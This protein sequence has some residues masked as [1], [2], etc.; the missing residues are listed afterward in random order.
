MHRPAVLC[1]AAAA[2]CAALLSVQACDD[3]GTK[4]E[5]LISS[6]SYSGHENDLDANA[7]VRAYPAAVGTRLDD[8]QMCHRAGVAATDTKNV[9]NA[10]SY[11][12]IYAFNDT[13]YV[14]GVP[15]SYHD[16]LNAFGL[17]YQSHGKGTA[18]LAAIESLDSDGDTYA[19]KDEIADNRFPG[20]AAS[21]PGQALAITATLS[22]AQISSMTQHSQF[23]LM[24]TSK[25]Q[26]DFYATYTGPTVKDLLTAAG[27]DLGDVGITGISVFAPD[28]FARDFTISQINTQY[29]DNL[30]YSV[31]QSAMALANQFVTYPM[32]IPTNPGTGSA[33]A[34]GDT[35]TDLWLTIASQRDGAALSTSYYDM[36]TKKLEGEGPYRIIPPVANTKAQPSF[37]R[38]DRGSTA[39]TL[40]DGWDYN[41]NLDHNAGNS[42]RGVVVIRVNPMPAGYEEYD[43]SNGWSLIASKQIVIYGRGVH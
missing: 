12:H 11:C 16:T 10:C 22:S 7:F 39:A 31:D 13:S 8:C 14:T 43:T 9:Y 23:L 30:Y 35:I 34:N 26:Y 36:T 32:V 25:Q 2:V 38:P 18:A 33:Y 3:P 5:D 40:G 15:T 37:S 27:V 21:N 4:T 1:L 24:N 42:N 6:R 29:A 17:D 20:N 19:N 28:G 41:S